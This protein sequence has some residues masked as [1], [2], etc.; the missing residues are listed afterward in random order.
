LSR[1]AISAVAS[2]RDGSTFLCA[3]GRTLTSNRV[4]YVPEQATLTPP[5]DSRSQVAVLGYN[6]ESLSEP[7][8]KALNLYATVI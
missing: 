2:S 4:V 3:L 8:L 5:I 1:T 6:H 7:S